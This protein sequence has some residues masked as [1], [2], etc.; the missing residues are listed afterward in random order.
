VSPSLLGQCC[1]CNIY[2][3][4]LNIY[5]VGHKPARSKS[6]KKLPMSQANSPN[7]VLIPEQVFSFS[8]RKLFAAFEQLDRSVVQVRIARSRIFYREFRVRLILRLHS[9]R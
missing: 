2:A 4:L 9:C 8:P 3:I 7:F 6:L 5:K 1:Y